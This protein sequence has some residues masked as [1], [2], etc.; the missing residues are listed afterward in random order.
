MKKKTYQQPKVQVI[1][2]EQTEIICASGGYNE[3][4]LLINGGDDLLIDEE[5][6]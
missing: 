6:W 5:V 1:E 3:G 2:F 4:S